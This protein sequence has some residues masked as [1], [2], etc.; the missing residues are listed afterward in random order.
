MK[1]VGKVGLLEAA[2]RTL[3]MV[4]RGRRQGEEAARGFGAPGAK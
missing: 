4:G 2:A 3:G 1:G